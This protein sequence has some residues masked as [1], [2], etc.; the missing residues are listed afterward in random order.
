VS[1]YTPSEVAAL[2]ERDDVQLIDV[3]TAA[4][5]E[6]GHIGGDRWIELNDLPSQA[7]TIDQDRPIIFYC[8]SGGRSS[9]ATDALQNA[10]YDAHNMAGGLLEWSASELP[11]EPADGHVADH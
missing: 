7:A 4:E 5:H 9:M 1:D 11:L 3:R 8:R 10:G 6:A 2:L